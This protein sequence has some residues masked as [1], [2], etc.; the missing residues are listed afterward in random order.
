MSLRGLVGLG[1]STRNLHATLGSRKGIRSKSN[2][3]KNQNCAFFFSK[4]CT[5][6]LRFVCVII[7][8]TCK[9]CA[10]NFSRNITVRTYKTSQKRKIEKR[11][12]VQTNLGSRVNGCVRSHLAHPKRRLPVSGAYSGSPSAPSL[13]AGHPVVEL[14]LAG[15]G[16][17][18]S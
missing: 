8:F 3:E 9:H 4:L 14:L 13:P 5:Q 15:G 6:S 12:I 17:Y 18:G 7:D 10:F 2:N 1:S 16:I 11:E